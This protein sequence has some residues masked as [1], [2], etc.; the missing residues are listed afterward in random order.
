MSVLEVQRLKEN[1]DRL[2]VAYAL[3]VAEQ[4]KQFDS[5]PDWMK[6]NSDT[7]R[8]L[9]ASVIEV[10]SNCTREHPSGRNFFCPVLDVSWA[11]QTTGEATSGPIWDVGNG[12][13]LHRDIEEAFDAELIIIV[14]YDNSKNGKKW[15]IRVVDKSLMEAEPIVDMVDKN[16][17]FRSINWKDI[18][19]REPDFRGSK[20]RPRRRYLYLHYVTTLLRTY[21]MK[22][23]G[24]EITM[25][26][27]K[28]RQV[29]ATS[30]KWY[31]PSSLRQLARYIAD[32]ADAPEL[33]FE[34]IST[35]AKALPKD[36]AEAMSFS[37]AFENEEAIQEMREEER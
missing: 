20:Q 16:D 2:G 12:L 22:R 4:F 18:H 30:G 11:S 17:N 7:Q 14:P 26:E 21:R 27:R 29:W 10:Y 24:W 36:G 1:M 37:V 35:D 28:S 33:F 9:K 23:P 8:E 25:Q 19:L 31:A 13:H 15:Q 34:A 32:D 3:S 5:V 6:K